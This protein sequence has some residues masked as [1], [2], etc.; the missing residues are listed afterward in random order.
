MHVFPES[1]ASRKNNSKS[2]A[3]NFLKTIE[4]SLFLIFR[5]KIAKWKE[6]QVGD[7]I[8]LKKNDFIPVSEQALCVSFLVLSSDMVLSFALWGLCVIG[9]FCFEQ[10]D[11]LLLSSSEPNSLCYVETAELDG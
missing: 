7:V 9:V 5:F 1:L 4:L 8:R 11:I 3:S 10:A 2:L 6:I